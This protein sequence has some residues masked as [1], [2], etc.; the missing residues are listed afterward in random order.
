[1]EKYLNINKVKYKKQNQNSL[2]HRSTN[3]QTLDD[4]AGLFCLRN[5]LF[6]QISFLQPFLYRKKKKKEVNFI[7]KQKK[8]ASETIILKLK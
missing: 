5:F 3:K 4:A 1:M 8:E 2:Q 6:S 7:V